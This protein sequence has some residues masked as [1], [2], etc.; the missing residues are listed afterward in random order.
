VPFEQ[1]RPLIGMGGDKVLPILT[2]RSIDEPKG[3]KIAERRD[4]IFGERYLP[5]VRP[6]PGARDLLLRLKADGFRLA[7][8]SSTEKELLRRLLNIVGT[9]EV[10]EKT[11]SS[12]DAD[13]SK[14]DPDIVRGA[15]RGLKEPPDSVVMIGDTPYDVE[16]GPA[17]EGDA[18]R[19]KLRWMEGRGSQGRDRDPRRPARPPEEPRRLGAV[20]G[21]RP[22]VPG[23]FDAPSRFSNQWCAHGSRSEGATST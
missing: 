21:R 13:N 19:V 10:F 15:L 11:A 2:G 6:L 1:M 18:D 7:V 14:P 9:P 12:D 22:L 23:A 3:K 8:A 20:R 5:Q 17:C 16:G 4:A